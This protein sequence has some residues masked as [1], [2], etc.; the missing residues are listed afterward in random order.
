MSIFLLVGM[1]HYFAFLNIM[2]QM[3]GMA[4]V[5]FSIRYVEKKDLKRFIICIIL[6][7][8]FHYTCF[9]FL[10]LYW[11]GMYRLSP[12]KIVIILIS[13]LLGYSLI[14]ELILKVIGLTKYSWYIGKTYGTGA[15][16]YVYLLIQIVILGLAVWQ[17]HDNGKYHIFLNIQLANTCLAYFSGQIVLIERFRYLFGFPSIILIPLAIKNMKNRREKTFVAISVVAAFTIYCYLVT[18]KGNHGV[19]PYRTILCT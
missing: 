16:G 1:T 7:G 11:L 5:I 6:A 4:I 13:V 12:K 17:Y 15:F 8:G 14:E 9:L 18:V 10:P 3:V 2:R 19:L